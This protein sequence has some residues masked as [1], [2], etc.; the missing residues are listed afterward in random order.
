MGAKDHKLKN[1]PVAR[2][3]EYVATKQ[4]IISECGK[5]TNYRKWWNYC[6]FCGKPIAVL[7]NDDDCKN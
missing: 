4:G 6:P 1:A 2:C 3:C 7:F 5:R